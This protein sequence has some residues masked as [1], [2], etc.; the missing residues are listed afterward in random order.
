MFQSR[1]DF[2]KQ[3]K[4]QKSVKDVFE[5]FFESEYNTPDISAETAQDVHERLLGTVSH[6]SFVC[7]NKSMLELVDIITK[8]G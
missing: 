3:R 8:H 4:G 1:L 7:E 2:L 5:Y 6:G